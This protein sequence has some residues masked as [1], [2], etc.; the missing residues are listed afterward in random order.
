MENGVYVRMVVL[1]CVLLN[2]LGGMKYELF[3]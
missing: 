1:K 3:V 2:V